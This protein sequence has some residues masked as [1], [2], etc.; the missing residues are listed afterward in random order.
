[1]LN[2]YY[3]AFKT[4]TLEYTYLNKTKKEKSINITSLKK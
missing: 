3:F 4:L 1:M 2:P